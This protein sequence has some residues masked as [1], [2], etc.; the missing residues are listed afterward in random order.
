MQSYFTTA[1]GQL[2][3]L[4]L[5]DCEMLNVDFSGQLKGQEPMGPFVIYGG[6]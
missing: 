3:R 4:L 5:W 2:V 1:F 6:I